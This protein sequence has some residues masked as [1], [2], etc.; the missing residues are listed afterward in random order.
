MPANAGDRGSESPG[1]MILEEEMATYRTFLPGK[2]LWAEESD[3]RTMDHKESMDLRA[4]THA[5]A[6]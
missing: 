6:Y 5:D 4:A 2:T 3:A 1:Q